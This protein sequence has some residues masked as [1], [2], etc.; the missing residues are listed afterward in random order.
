LRQVDI[1][2]DE[3]E[4]VVGPDQDPPISCSVEHSD[5]SGELGDHLFEQLGSDIG[6]D[7]TAVI[8]VTGH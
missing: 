1:G 7:L 8:A 6:G 3:Q 5:R 2:G 4:T